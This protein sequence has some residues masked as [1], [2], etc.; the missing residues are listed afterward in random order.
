V[1]HTDK[2]QPC[3]TEHNRP[4][5]AAA[6]RGELR[7]QRCQGCGHVRYPIAPTCP[8]CLCDAA[9]WV[10]LAGRGAIFACVVYHRAFGN[11]FADEV[12][13][14]VA[15]VQLE[16]GP[17]MLSDIV[18]TAEGVRVNV[19]D[20]VEVVFD[21]ITPECTVPRFRLSESTS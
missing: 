2:P 7:L 19:G 5:W 17:R 12:P 16:E 13:Y 15:I 14:V 6:R 9:E 18:G 20:R 21:A 1:S 8:V 11:A 10:L 3:I 4:F